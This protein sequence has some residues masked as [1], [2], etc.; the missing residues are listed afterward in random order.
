L[1]PSVVEF[2]LDG[3]VFAFFLI[4]RTQDLEFGGLEGTVWKSVLWIARRRES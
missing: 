4:L 1:Y 3:D 2:R